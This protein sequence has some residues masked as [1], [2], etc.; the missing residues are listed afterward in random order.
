MMVMEST[1]ATFKYLNGLVLSGVKLEVTFMGRQH[2]IVISLAMSHNGT[3]VA[4]GAPD[5]HYG[6]GDSLGSVRVFEWNEGNDVEHIT[7]KEGS[8]GWLED[9]Q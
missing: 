1:L 8:T 5:N 6:N 7:K 9:I 2:L 3:T 4:V